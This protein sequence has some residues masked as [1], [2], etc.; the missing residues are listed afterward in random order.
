MRLER[1]NMENVLWW[2]NIIFYT[3]ATFCYWIDGP[4]GMIAFHIG[5]RPA[6]WESNL[7]RRGSWST[8]DD[9]R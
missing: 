1:T 6:T 3:L 8:D 7:G 4:I 9:R 5:A 2:M